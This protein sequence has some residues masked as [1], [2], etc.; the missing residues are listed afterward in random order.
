MRLGISKNALFHDDGAP[1][2][3]ALGDML[4]AN[5]SEL[6]ELD[7]SSNG[8]YP[9]SK[10]GPSF[11]QALSAGISDNRALS[12]ANVM[13]N[14]IGKEMVSK[15]QEIMRSKPNLISLCGIANDATGAD[16]SGLCMDVDDAIILA[17]ELPNKGAL[18]SLN[19]SS[20][21]LTGYSG[22]EMSGKVVYT[23]FFLLTLSSFS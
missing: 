16:L 21:G 12:I 7:V 9:S 11:V 14:R 3:K 10:G 20:N 4:A 18:T 6:Q 1:A 22:S 15:L 23:A 19:L 8:Q 13:G 5:S 2:G 17:T